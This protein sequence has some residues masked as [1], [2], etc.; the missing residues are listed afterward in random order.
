MLLSQEKH[1]NNLSIQ[2]KDYGLRDHHNNDNSSDSYDDSL[3]DLEMSL[4]SI[5]TNSTQP[6]HQ[7]QQQQQQLPKHSQ[8]PAEQRNPLAR[9]GMRHSFSGFYDDYPPSE[10]TTSSNLHKLSHQ[11]KYTNYR[12]SMTDLDYRS[13][14]YDK[15][16]YVLNNSHC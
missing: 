12:S 3:K 2:I 9:R 15:S 11:K 5:P 8:Q 14:N 4:H 13:R 6:M 7:Q 1:N 16:A 10:S